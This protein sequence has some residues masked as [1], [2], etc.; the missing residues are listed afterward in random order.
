VPPGYKISERPM[1]IIYL[2]VN[3][4]ERYES[5]DYALSTRTDDCSTFEEK[6][7]LSGYTYDD[8]DNVSA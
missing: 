8:N 5:N 7:S 1:Q 4:T 3:H 2:P 6:K